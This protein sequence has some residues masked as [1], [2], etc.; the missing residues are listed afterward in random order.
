V[1]EASALAGFLISACAIEAQE[2]TIQRGRAF[3]QANC[4]T[5]QSAGFIESL[6][7]QVLVTFVL[8]TRLNPLAYPSYCCLLDPGLCNQS[9]NSGK[10]RPQTKRRGNAPTTGR[11]ASSALSCFSTLL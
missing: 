6:A 9:R 3:A 7:T 4:A 8:R 5:W 2:P 11:D 1:I 10:R